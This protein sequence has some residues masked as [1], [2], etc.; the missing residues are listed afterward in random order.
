M[1]CD[2]RFAVMANV[3]KAPTSMPRKPLIAVRHR[4]ILAV[5]PSAP[6]QC[7]R[8]KTC[9]GPMTC[10]AHLSGRLSKHL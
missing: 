2:A 8:L 5:L 9:L 7:H 10:R 6:F 1:R 3:S 4:V